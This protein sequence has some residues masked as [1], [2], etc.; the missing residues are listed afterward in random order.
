M[1]T[2]TFRTDL[3]CNSCVGKAKPFLDAEKTIS[4]WSVDIADERKPL[5]VKGHH[6]DSEAVRRAVEKSGFH[7]FE[8]ITVA[9]PGTHPAPEVEPGR[10]VLQTYYPLILIFGYLAGLTILPSLVSGAWN[11]QSMMHQFMGGFFLAFSFFKLLNLRGFADAYRTYDIVAKAVPA[12]GFVYP[13]MELGLGV[14]Y[15]TGAAPTVTNLVTVVVMGVSSIG[16]IQSLLKKRAIQCACL[17]TIFNL[18]MTKITLFED[19]LMVAMAGTGLL[20]A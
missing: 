16:V 7:V 13:F 17:G 15:F 2:R 20:N 10:S 9:P 8:D 18:P 4:S 19:L 12:Y 1:E 11:Y 14:A 6:V 5:T 3:N